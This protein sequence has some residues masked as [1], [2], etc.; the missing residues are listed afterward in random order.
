MG[1]VFRGYTFLRRFALIY[2]LVQVAVKFFRAIWT[3]SFA[4]GPQT[5]DAGEITFVC[6][7]EMK[8]SKSMHVL[9]RVCYPLAE[10]PIIMVPHHHALLCSSHPS[11]LTSSTHT[12]IKPSG[13]SCHTSYVAADTAIRCIPEMP[14]ENAECVGFVLY[15]GRGA[16]VLST[17]VF[18]LFR[19]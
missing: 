7:L 10:G 15:H 6:T 8:V 13:C 14:D 12:K 9:F 5:T 11:H 2:C 19:H 4:R 17:W 3:P 18:Y 16:L 1:K